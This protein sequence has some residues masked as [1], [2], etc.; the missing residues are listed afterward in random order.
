MDIAGFGICRKCRKSGSEFRADL[1]VYLCVG[2]VQEILS[3]GPY[4]KW[5]VCEN[6][7]RSLGS[8]NFVSESSRK[9]K[10]CIQKLKFKFTGVLNA[11]NF[12]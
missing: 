12:S 10:N 6:C 7:N 5:R 3:D 4:G 1:G 2:C 9:C 8:Y 11:N